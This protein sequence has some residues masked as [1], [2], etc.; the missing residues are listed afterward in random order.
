MSKWFSPLFHDYS[1]LFMFIIFKKIH[2]AILHSYEYVTR[3]TL[4]SFAHRG[5][6]PHEVFV[7]VEA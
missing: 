4:M 5:Y 7:C 3:S 1:W 6:H 2:G